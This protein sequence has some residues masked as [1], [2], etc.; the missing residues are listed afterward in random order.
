VT[1]NPISST[2]S[3]YEHGMELT[4]RLLTVRQRIDGCVCVCACVCVCVC[5]RERE[6]E[7]MKRSQQTASLIT[8][9]SVNLIILNTLQFFS[10]LYGTEFFIKS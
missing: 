6:A 10:L 1:N 2:K 5:V 9:L 8:P 3:C 4:L 7:R